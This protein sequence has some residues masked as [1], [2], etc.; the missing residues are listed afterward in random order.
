MTDSHLKAEASDRARW[1]AALAQSLKGADFEKK[2][3]SRTR[4]NLRIEPLYAK[5]DSAGAG[6]WRAGGA[7]RWRVAQR[8]DHPDP[9]AANALARADIEGGAEELVLVLASPLAPHRHGLAAPDVRALDDALSGIDLK[10]V[11]L[12]LARGPG[13]RVSAALV[14]A[15]VERR[16]LD[17]AALALEFGIDPVGTLAQ[18]GRLAADWPDIARRVADT[19]TGLR[20]AGFRGPVTIADGTVWHEAGASEAQELAATLAT[21]VAYLRVAAEAGLDLDAARRILSAQMAAD[22]DVF[23]TLA[24]FRALRRLWARVEDACGLTPAPLRLHA[25]TAWRMLARRDPWTNLLRNTLAATGAA[26]GGADTLSVLPFTAALGLPDESARRLARNTALI[27][28]EE[29]QLW[30]VI[31]PAAGSGAFEALTDDLCETA[32]TLFQEIEAQAAPAT[33]GIVAALQSGTLQAAIGRVRATLQHDVATRKTPLIG[34]SEF[35]DLAEMPVAVLTPKTIARRTGSLAPASNGPVPDRFADQVAAFR[36]GATR[37]ALTPA[38][39]G[40]LRGESLPP[41]RLA[42]P[43]EALRDAAE[44]YALSHGS[45]PRIFLA[46]LGPLAAF[47]ARAGFARGLFE[48]GGIAALG[49]EP[50]QTASG[51]TDPA[52]L[53]AAWRASGAALACLCGTD[54]A[55]AAEAEAAARAL[56]EAGCRQIYL[57]GTPG[58]TAAAL[59]AAGVT[60]WIHR[61]IDVVATLRA[62]HAAL[63]ELSAPPSRGPR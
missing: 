27:L 23:L 3:V 12:R 6:P 20:A 15:L 51:A 61:G 63:R 2:L 48:A 21:L 37:D 18:A 39:A 44:A 9:E 52:A 38:P 62:A 17:P 49:T 29:A 34:V 30:R 5:A 10:N 31:D 25:E 24:K 1:L 8:I 59:A 22:A 19:A 42:E 35:P 14:A 60:D 33:P 47:A 45:P 32:W 50:C 41:S 55:Y 16:K 57:A 13:S 4:D 7:A 26:L 54:D 56:R 46:G 58:E 43:Y 28:R 11:R 53:V 40:T 36:T